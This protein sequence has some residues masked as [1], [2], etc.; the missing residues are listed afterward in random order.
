[1]PLED[2][3]LPDEEVRYQ[4]PD[5]VEYGGQRYTV[6]VTNKRLLLYAKRGLIFKKEDVVSER[7]ED[8]QTLNFKEKGIFPKKGI[9]EVVTGK[10]KWQFEGRANS[11]KA[12]F[13]SLQE[14]LGL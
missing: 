5:E 11:M 7:I 9:I 4:S 8:I 6:L 1:M 2:Y 14:H 3:F 10:R 12:L 13:M